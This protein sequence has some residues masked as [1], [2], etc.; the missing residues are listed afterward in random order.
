MGK[1]KNLLKNFKHKQKW[2]PDLSHN[3]TC[4]LPEV[5]YDV[6]VSDEHYVQNKDKYLT[7]GPRLW[8]YQKLYKMAPL[9]SHDLW[10]LYQNDKEAKEQNLFPSK[11]SSFQRP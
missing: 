2:K 8:I 10:E 11:L 3:W 6:V 1:I 4:R 9:T 5:E 7:K